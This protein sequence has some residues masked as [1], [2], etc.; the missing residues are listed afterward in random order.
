ML[1]AVRMIFVLRDPASRTYSH[2]WHL[3][4]TGRATGS[5]EW[6]LRRR[7]GTLIQRSLYREQLER[8]LA[9]FPR[10]QL[11]VVAFERLVTEPMTALADVGRF[12]GRAE[13]H[14]V[15][16]DALHRNRAQV[17][18]VP[19]LQRLVNRMRRGRS[20]APLAHVPGSG[21]RPG[22]RSNQSMIRA[23]WFREGQV[24]P[25]RPDTRDFLNSMFRN[26]NR[27]LDELLGESFEALWYRNG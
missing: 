14:E 8:Y 9:R 23:A 11:H 5:F 19:A 16:P 15:P 2:Y 6:M 17:P 18:R 24:S 10:D 12:L 22:S 25:M 21:H 27:G 7:P 4:R 3:M 13:I 1:P 26:E 20:G